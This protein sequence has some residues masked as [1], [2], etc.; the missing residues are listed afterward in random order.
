MGRMPFQIVTRATKVLCKSK[1][2][3]FGLWAIR[4]EETI[5]GSKH[6]HEM[7]RS[8]HHRWH[9]LQRETLHF[10]LSVDPSINVFYIS[11]MS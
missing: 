1:S 6:G 7:T 3:E 11:V 10:H 4:E 8:M 2:R 9:Q 5:G